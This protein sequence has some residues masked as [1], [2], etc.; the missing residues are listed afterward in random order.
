MKKGVDISRG[1]TYLLVNKHS[2]ESF[3]PGKKKTG[4]YLYAST[5]LRFSGVNIYHDTGES[6]LKPLSERQLEYLRNVLLLICSKFPLINK[7]IQT[8]HLNLVC[9]I[10]VR[11]HSIKNESDSRS[12][13]YAGSN[14]SSWLITASLITAVLSFFFWFVHRKSRGVNLTTSYRYFCEF[15]PKSQK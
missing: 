12:A 11:K 6:I 2:Q 10:F 13:K 9:W 3:Y 7:F 1:S 8:Y 15:G 14:R 4:E 5:Y